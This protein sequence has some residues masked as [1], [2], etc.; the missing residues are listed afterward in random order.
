M[1]IK[2][3]IVFWIIGL[4]ASLLTM[5]AVYKTIS[6]E[7][8]KK[9]SNKIIMTLSIMLTEVIKIAILTVLSYFIF[10]YPIVHGN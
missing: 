10:R 7:I 1:I 9:G 2:S 3:N 8:Y 5:F 6:N 4:S